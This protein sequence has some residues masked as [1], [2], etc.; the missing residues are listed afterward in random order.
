MDSNT[1]Y[2]H[3]TAKY[4]AIQ[5]KKN[6]SAHLSI[7]CPAPHNIPI[8]QHHFIREWRKHR[9]LTQVQLAERVGMYQGNLSKI[10]SGSRR[11]I[12][13]S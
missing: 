11:M 8:G 9:G 13:S 3:I 6:M 5:R 4:S 1:P 7:I 12:R 2:R 10:E